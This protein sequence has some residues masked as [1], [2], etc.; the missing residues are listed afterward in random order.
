MDTPQSL[1]NHSQGALVDFI[2][3][4]LFP[5][6]CSLV[7]ANARLPEGILRQPMG[8]VAVLSPGPWYVLNS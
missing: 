6:E 7:S 2:L 3:S 5:P 1:P 4:P 8:V